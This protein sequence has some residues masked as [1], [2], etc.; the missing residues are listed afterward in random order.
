MHGEAKSIR[1][2]PVAKF[3]TVTIIVALT[4]W[5]V[6]S[7]SGIT[8]PFVAAAI[9]T[10]LFNPLITLLNRRLRISRALW[11][12]VLYVAIGILIYGLVRYLGPIVANQYRDLRY[13]LIPS[14][15]NG[16][17]RMPVNQT[18]ELGGFGLVQ[19]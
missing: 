6:S 18:I 5:L 1:L 13:R 7:V 8:T 10:Y 17:N 15:I 16:L 14:I 11:I 4:I 9:T 19:K 2:S 3:I 12:V